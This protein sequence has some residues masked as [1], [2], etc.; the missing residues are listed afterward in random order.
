MSKVLAA[1]SDNDIYLDPQGNIA[2]RTGLEAVMQSCENAAKAQ[3]KEMVLA[4]NQGVANFQTIWTNAANVAQY[5][6]Y[7]RRAIKAVA[8]VTE[9]NDLTVTVADHIVKYSATISTVYGSA[10]LNG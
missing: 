6:A 1:N 10:V 4:Y 2:I 8:G 5:E 3:L 9:V 7:V